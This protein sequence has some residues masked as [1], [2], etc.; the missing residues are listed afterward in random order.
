MNFRDWLLN[1]SNPHPYQISHIDP[2]GYYDDEGE[3]DR[4]DMGRQA[5]EI[6]RRSTIHILRD[7]QLAAVSHDA[8][9]KVAGALYTSIQDNYFTF[10]VVVDQSAQGQGI[11]T[12][13]VQ[14]AIDDFKSQRAMYD[15]ML[16]IKADVVSVTMEHILLKM[17]WKV[18][19]RIGGHAIMTPPR[20]V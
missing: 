10:D 17:G 3:L 19:K 1:E 15:G 9:G 8:Q 13:L 5:D 11:G 18:R 12:K 2:E 20:A 7:K 4:H 14:W 6:S 16:K